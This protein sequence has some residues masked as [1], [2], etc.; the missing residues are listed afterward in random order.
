M[1]A[2]VDLTEEVVYTSRRAWLHASTWTPGRLRISSRSLRFTAQDGATTEVAL[3]ALDDV[4]VLRLPRP[5]LVLR[6]DSGTLRL[7]C[8]AVPAIAALLQ[9]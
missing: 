5:A 2:D 7:R 6:T 9:R 4:R 3:T 8:F 1:V